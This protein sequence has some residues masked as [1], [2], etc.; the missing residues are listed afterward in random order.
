MLDIKTNTT[1]Y[2][3]E[4]GLKG[5]T[6]LSVDRWKKKLN[7]TKINIARIFARR[8]MRMLCY[9]PLPISVAGYLWLPIYLGMSVSEFFQRLYRR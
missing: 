4:M 7:V 9:A 1:A 8:Q 5:I 6:A 2:Q 3:E